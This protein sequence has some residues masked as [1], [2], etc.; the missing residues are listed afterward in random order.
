MKQQVKRNVQ[1]YFA[2]AGGSIEEGLAKACD[3]HAEQI[4]EMGNK[5]YRQI[6][7]LRLNNLE[8]K[9]E[10]AAPTLADK[11]RM[12]RKQIQQAIYGLEGEV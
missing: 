12:D 4:K 5:Y 9:T 8:Q 3:T 11:Y 7:N 2:K 6:I 10:T 1:D